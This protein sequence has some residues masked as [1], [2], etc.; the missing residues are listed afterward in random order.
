M[1]SR[2]VYTGHM[3]DFTKTKILSHANSWTARLFKEAWLS[4]KLQ[5]TY[6]VWREAIKKS[7]MTTVGGEVNVTYSRF[8]CKNWSFV[9]TTDCSKNLKAQQASYTQIPMFAFSLWYLLPGITNFQQ[10]STR[11]LEGNLKAAEW[12]Q[13][14]SLW[15]IRRFKFR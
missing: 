12:H 7:S 2:C 11:W 5:Q 14:I 1:A 10:V 3:F 13:T 6:S 8:F 15:S 9:L 4:K